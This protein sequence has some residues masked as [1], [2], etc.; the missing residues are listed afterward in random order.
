MATIVR[1]RDIRADAKF[2]YPV[3]QEYG[4]DSSTV[5]NIDPPFTLFHALIPPGH[6][7]RAHYHI[8]STQGQ[9]YLK[10]RLR[11]YF[12]PKH[13][14][15]TVDIEAGDYLYLPRGIIHH[16]VN[17]SDTETVEILCAYVGVTSRFESG[18]SDAEPPHG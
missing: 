17:L 3:L 8:N 13:D 10:G 5:E 2:S 4:I 15:K 12:G 1:K 9:Y 11:H 14:E 7:N 16:G 6:K 18:K